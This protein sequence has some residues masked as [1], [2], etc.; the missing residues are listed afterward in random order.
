MIYEA[1]K[2]NRDEVYEQKKKFVMDRKKFEE[3]FNLEKIMKAQQLKQDLQNA[4]VK[5]EQMKIKK[6]QDRKLRYI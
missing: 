2:M 1:K 6:D 3:S 5:N 4:K